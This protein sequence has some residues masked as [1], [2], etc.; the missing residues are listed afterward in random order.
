MLKKAFCS[1]YRLSFLHYLIDNDIHKDWIRLITLDIIESL[2]DDNDFIIQNNNELT[3]QLL[4]KGTSSFNE[5]VI[6]YDTIIKIMSNL[7]IN[8]NVIKNEVKI[9]LWKLTGIMM[10]LY[11]RSPKD[12]IITSDKEKMCNVINYLYDII[13][14]NPCDSIF[15]YAIACMYILH[16]E[17]TIKY[18]FLAKPFTKDIVDKIRKNAETHYCV[19]PQLIARMYVSYR[20]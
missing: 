18:S 11:L 2:S 8:D 16:C 5:K 9:Q 12:Y 4:I 10:K 13:E 15:Y 3:F 17:Y 7:L 19:G 1:D 14:S 20:P 6:S